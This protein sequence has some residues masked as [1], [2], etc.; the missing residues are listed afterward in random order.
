MKARTYRQVSSVG[1][2][3][4]VCLGLIC[5]REKTE[6]EVLAAATSLKRLDVLD[7]SRPMLISDCRTISDGKIELKKGCTGR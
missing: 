4:S 1:V 5:Q 2:R 3:N 7:E 6:P